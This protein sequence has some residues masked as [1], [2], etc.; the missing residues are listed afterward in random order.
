MKTFAANATLAVLPRIVWA[1]LKL[2]ASTSRMRVYGEEYPDQ[3]RQAGV[4]FIYSFWHNR[5]IILPIIRDDEPIHCLISSSRDGEYIAR[6]AAMF[7]K[8][9]VRGS[10]TRGGFEA[11]LQ[12]MRILKSNGIVAVTPDGPLGPP[13]QVKPGIVQIARALG[14]P[15]V[16][17]A[18]DCSR[19]KVFAS[20]DGFNMPY[21]FGRIAIVF[22]QPLR[23]SEEEPVT[24]GCQRLKKALDDTTERAT[25][26][27]SDSQ[28]QREDLSTPG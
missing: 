6:V 4:G 17:V 19:K 12:I 9:A 15:V 25:S 23:F 14:A 3:L 5:Q 26:R 24:E 22:G 27:L 1:Y 8:A 13:L 28:G 21:P 16:P 11:M 18:F 2:I 10:S 20:W 7:G